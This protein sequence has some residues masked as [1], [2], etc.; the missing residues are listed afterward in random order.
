M[1][2]K[3]HQVV[4]ML[5][6][7]VLVTGCLVP[8]RF[9]AKI[10][11]K[12]D[13]SY[14]FKYSGIT[15]FALAAAQIKTTGSLPQKEEVALEAE[16]Q[17]ISKKPYVK[18]V[19]YKGNARYDIEMEGEKKPGQALDLLDFFFVK[20]DKDGVIT[21]SSKTLNEK[22]RQELNGLGIVMKGTLDVSL[23]RNIELISHNATS[24]P[25]LGFGT[26]TW[27]IGRTDQQPILKLRMKN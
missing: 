8:E 5:T 27:K 15:V 7:F 9:D 17:K 22:Q 4:V 25:T 10:D 20:I 11:L 16:A 1:K 21:I 14:T 19:V 26:Y 18:K 24:T 6:C 12:P 23:P 13:A 2:I 3:L